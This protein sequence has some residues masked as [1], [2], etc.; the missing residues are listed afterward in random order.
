EDGLQMRAS[1]LPYV[2]RSDAL[3][4]VELVRGDGHEVQRQCMNVER[5]LADRLRSVRVKQ[6]AAGTAECADRGDILDHSDLVVDEHDGYE[7]GVGAQRRGHR[8]RID[9]AGAVGRD[10][11][12]G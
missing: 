2:D 7:R 6:N 3:G 10:Q 9:P 12:D 5:Y 11:A 1:F 8:V 4:T